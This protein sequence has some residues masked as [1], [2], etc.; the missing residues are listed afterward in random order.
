[1]ES[2]LVEITLRPNETQFSFSDGDNSEYSI[3]MFD[4]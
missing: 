2:V 1:M 3:S 4:F